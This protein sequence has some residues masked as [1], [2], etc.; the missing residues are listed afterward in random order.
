MAKAAVLLAVLLPG[1][2]GCTAQEWE[3]ALA[4]PPP[5]TCFLSEEEGAQTYPGC[6]WGFSS[7]WTFDLATRVATLDKVAPR[8][9]CHYQW[10]PHPYANLCVVLRKENTVVLAHALSWSLV[11]YYHYMEHGRM[12]KVF[13][14]SGMTHHIAAFPIALESVNN[15]QVWDLNLNT[16]VG[17]GPIVEP[18]GDEGTAAA[19]S[20]RN[21]RRQ[22]NRARARSCPDEALRA[23]L[24]PLKFSASRGNAVP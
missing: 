23:D 18:E 8:E 14:N 5:P 2:S 16:L 12:T 11:P 6:T 3:R 4:G 9:V 24:R 19:P 15:Y 7:G 13:M 21:A 1:L 22:S 20:L 10:R 17:A